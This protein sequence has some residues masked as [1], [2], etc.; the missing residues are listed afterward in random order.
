METQRILFQLFSKQT[1]LQCHN[2]PTD[3][4]RQCEDTVRQWREK[5]EVLYDA[6]EETKLIDTKDSCVTSCRHFKY[7]S[8]YISFSLTNDYD[9]EQRLTLETQSMGALKSV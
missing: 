4:D 1:I 9:I 6:L 2:A 8:S 5:E 7:L 3:S